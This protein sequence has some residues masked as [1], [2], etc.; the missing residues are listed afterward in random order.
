MLHLHWTFYYK[1]H[2]N[3]YYIKNK[4]WIPYK[5][6]IWN[7]F[8]SGYWDI[9]L[10]LPNQFSSRIIQLYV[11]LQ[12]LVGAVRLYLNYACLAYLPLGDALTII[13]T[14]P[15]FT[16]IFSCVAFHFRMGIFRMTLAFG[17]LSGMILCVQPPLIFDRWS[18]T[19]GLK[20]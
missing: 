11:A 15:L 18:F 4:I 19:L 7:Y 20:D 10:N 14:E 9:F 16:M 3:F 6:F 12:G 17:L 5:S 1:S 8:L 2:S 13:F